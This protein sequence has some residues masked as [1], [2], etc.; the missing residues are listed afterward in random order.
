[1][2]RKPFNVTLIHPGAYIHSAA[3]VI[4]PATEAP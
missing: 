2:S 1:M 3:P 4:A